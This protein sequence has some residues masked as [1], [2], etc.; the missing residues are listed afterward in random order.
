[1]QE[2]EFPSKKAFCEMWPS[3]PDIILDIRLPHFNTGV[4]WEITP[5]PSG[6]LASLEK[7]LDRS[8][9]FR[10]GADIVCVSEQSWRS[11]MCWEDVTQSHSALQDPLGARGCSLPAFPV[12]HLQLGQH[13][14]HWQ[15][16]LRPHAP[17]PQWGGAVKFGRALDER[18]P[19]LF[20]LSGASYWHG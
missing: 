13:P 16:A 12:Q 2:M 20:A 15:A 6:G 3:V 4:H 11:R 19:A 14:V 10:Q 7:G 18:V 9:I 17:L 8:G 1:M 5:C